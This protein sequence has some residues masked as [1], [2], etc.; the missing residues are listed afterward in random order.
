M[1]PQTCTI[2]WVHE[3]A[4]GPANPALPGLPRRAWLIRVR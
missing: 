2:L 1:D 3:E 4:L